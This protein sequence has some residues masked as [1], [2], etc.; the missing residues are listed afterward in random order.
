[1]ELSDQTF[2]NNKLMNI[3]M[4]KQN[5]GANFKKKSYQLYNNWEGIYNWSEKLEAC[6]LSSFHDL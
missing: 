4:P 6:K 3:K 2:N 5:L 1:M